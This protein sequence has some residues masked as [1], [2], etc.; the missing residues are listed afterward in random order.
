MKGRTRTSTDRVATPELPFPNKRP[1]DD[2]GA[3]K[4]PP[5]G[6]RTV[7]RSAAWPALAIVR[8][9]A[10][11]RVPVSAI[12]AISG[13]INGAAAGPALPLLAREPPPRP[14]L[15]QLHLAQPTMLRGPCPDPLSSIDRQHQQQHRRGCP[16]GHRSAR[17]LKMPPTAPADV[18]PVRTLR[19]AH[20]PRSLD[21]P[22]HAVRV[23]GITA[24]ASTTDP[25]SCAAAADWPLNGRV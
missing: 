11:P 24:P 14:P 1:V 2:A 16:R 17:L 18:R 22:L 4:N 7:S 15:A 8:T 12:A 6:G 21:E 20:G 13:K 19:P 25:L 5:A 9:I 23:R 3:P 10:Q